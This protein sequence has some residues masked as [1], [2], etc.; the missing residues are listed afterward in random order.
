M[1]KSV[2]A[3]LFYR[4]NIKE[5]R[6]RR[7]LSNRKTL[8]IFVKP[9]MRCILDESVFAF[10][11]DKKSDSFK[12]E[13]DNDD[14]HH[15]YWYEVNPILY[16]GVGS[17]NCF[18][19]LGFCQNLLSDKR[20]CSTLLCFIISHIGAGWQQILLLLCWHLM[21]NYESFWT[22]TLMKSCTKWEKN[23]IRTALS[24]HLV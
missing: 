3:V 23:F 9:R 24:K 5:T 21:Q 1:L 10:I 11:L 4:I 19:L 18:I 16:T 13:E 8:F 17:C 12:Q 22:H 7:V 6:P 15:L 20:N 2:L 14:T